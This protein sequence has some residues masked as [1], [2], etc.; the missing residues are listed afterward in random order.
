MHNNLFSDGYK[1]EEMQSLDKWKFPHFPLHTAT[2]I[3]TPTIGKK[4]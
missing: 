3:W 2:S 4:R 1:A